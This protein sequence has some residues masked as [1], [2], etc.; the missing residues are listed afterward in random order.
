MNRPKRKSLVLLFR[1]A[2]LASAL[3]SFREQKHF[4]VEHK[5]TRDP[6]SI[7]QKMC[8]QQSLI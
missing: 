3:L 7:Y 5:N 4:G 8:R 1:V 6:W 2:D